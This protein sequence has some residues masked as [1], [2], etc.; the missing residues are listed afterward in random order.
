[1]M[2]G[3][4]PHDSGNISDIGGL[5]IDMEK[6]IDPPSSCLS[7]ADSMPWATDIQSFICI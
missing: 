7:I 4:Q 5:W 2:D 3:R 1:M 6:L